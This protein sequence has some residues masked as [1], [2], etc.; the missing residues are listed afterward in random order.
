MLSGLGHMA[1]ALSMC[2]DIW[3]A[4]PTQ[5]C[6]DRN[7]SRGVLGTTGRKAKGLQQGFTPGRKI[8]GGC[9]QLRLFSLL[10]ARET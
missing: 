3:G 5:E 10:S 2:L 9:E 8:C 6:S 4:L 1:S 7:G